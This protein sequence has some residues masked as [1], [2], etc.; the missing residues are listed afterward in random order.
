MT[1]YSVVDCPSEQV[2]LDG[3]MVCPIVDNFDYSFNG[4]EVTVTWN[5]DAEEFQEN[6]LGEELRFYPALNGC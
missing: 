6:T 5:G 1:A 2:C 3:I 4:N